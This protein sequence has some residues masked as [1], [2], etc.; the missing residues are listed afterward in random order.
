[1]SKDLRGVLSTVESS[2]ADHMEMSKQLEG[3]SRSLESFKQSTNF[4]M[5]LYQSKE[6]KQVSEFFKKYNQQN[7]S[8]PEELWGL[9]KVIERQQAEIKEL[10]KTIE[11]NPLAAERHAKCLKLEA[12]IKLF[13]SIFDQNGSLK[14]DS[15]MS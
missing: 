7:S 1:M 9:Q 4:R 5:N 8:A 13:N 6:Y 2:F 12:Q 15:F 10:K 3:F 11:I 14:I